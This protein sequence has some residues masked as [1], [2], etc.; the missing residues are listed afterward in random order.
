MT[1]QTYQWGIENTHDKMDISFIFPTD[2]K[3]KMV[4]SFKY[5][6]KFEPSFSCLIASVEKAILEEKDYHIREKYIWIKEKYSHLF[7]DSKKA[8]KD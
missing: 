8:S 6:N 2:D 5:F 1:E 3:L 4:E 7:N